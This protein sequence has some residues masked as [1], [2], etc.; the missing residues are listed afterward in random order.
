MLG[1]EPTL[2]NNKIDDSLAEKRNNLKKKKEIT[3]VQFH[4]HYNR[5][6]HRVPKN[7]R[8]RLGHLNKR[9]KHGQLVKV[10]RGETLTK[11]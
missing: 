4:T 7:R 8:K 1:V 10:S 6:K 11:W 2:K 9:G 3:S 5:A